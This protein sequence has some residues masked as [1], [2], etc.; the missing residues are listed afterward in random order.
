MQINVRADRGTVIHA[1]HPDSRRP[2]C[3]PIDRRLRDPWYNVNFDDIT[4]RRCLKKLGRG[5]PSAKRPSAKVAA[6]RV[7]KN[8]G[9]EPKRD[10]SIHDH[11]MPMS[12]TSGL[13]IVQSTTV[14]INSGDGEKTVLDNARQIIELLWTNEYG[15]HGFHLWA[16]QRPSAPERP[17]VSLD[18]DDTMVRY[19]SSQPSYRRV[20]SRY[21][22]PD[23][24]LMWGE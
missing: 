8:L 15:R 16:E 6:T 24:N 7:L 1:A 17:W 23:Q 11:L 20:A 18:N 12:E 22:L 5:V 19:R 3:G 9:L 2:L 14:F 21:D 10:F 13:R 4:C